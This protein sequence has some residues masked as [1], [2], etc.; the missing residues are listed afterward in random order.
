MQSID[1]KGKSGKT[2]HYGIFK[3]G[4]EFDEMPGNYVFAQETQPGTF[5][6]IYIGETGNLNERFDDHHRMHCIKREGATHIT[7]HGAYGG[8]E[9]RRAE[10]QDIKNFYNPPCNG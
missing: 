8:E 3:I 6:P 5:R 2:Y 7:A 4:I 1:W 9:G 10:E